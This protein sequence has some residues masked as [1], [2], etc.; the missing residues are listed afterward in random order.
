MQL[1]KLTGRD[2]C[3]WETHQVT[4]ESLKTDCILQQGE[5]SLLRVPFFLKTMI[6]DFFLSSGAFLN[7]NP[8]NKNNKRMLITAVFHFVDQVQKDR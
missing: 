6:F 1:L 3:R 5:V 2:I 4:A 7:H 8:I